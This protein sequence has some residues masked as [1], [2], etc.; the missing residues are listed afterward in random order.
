MEND[1]YKQLK[2]QA[3]KIHSG[4]YVNE[5]KYESKSIVN[6]GL[7][8]GGIGIVYAMFANKNTFLFGITG[9][10][11]GVIMAVAYNKIGKIKI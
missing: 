9:F 10:L 6:G 3:S 11:A 5:M 8:F 2:D 1:L 4:E 7:I